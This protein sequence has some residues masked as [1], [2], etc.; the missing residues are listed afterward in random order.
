ML[1]KNIHWNFI[2]ATWILIFFLAYK[3]YEY[4]FILGFDYFEAHYPFKTL[5]YF[6][7]PTILFCIQITIWYRFYRKNDAGAKIFAFVVGVLILLKYVIAPLIANDVYGEM[8][9]MPMLTL[10]TESTEV[11]SSSI[12]AVGYFAVSNFL[13]ALF[14][15]T[16]NSDIRIV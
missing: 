1:Q 8:R 15:R 10:N 11:S 2:F 14:Y 3:I 5:R 16:G 12:Y 9:N 13:Y 6:F 7:S 4:Y